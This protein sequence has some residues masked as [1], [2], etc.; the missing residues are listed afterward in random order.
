VREV[1]REVQDAN[2]GRSELTQAVHVGVEFDSVHQQEF[3]LAR[4]PGAEMTRNKRR[5]RAPQV[6][7]EARLVTTVNL[8]VLPE[9][10]R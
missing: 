5:L 8:S 3:P 6:H 7:F 2:F 9:L 1:R 4:L 10:W